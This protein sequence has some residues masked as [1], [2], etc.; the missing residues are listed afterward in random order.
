LDELL[1]DAVALRMRS[2][3]PIGAFLSGGIDSSTVVAMMQAESS[4]NV[5]TY[6]IGFT[7]P[8][9]D[10]A[11]WARAVARRL[12]TD[13]TELYVTG[14]EALGVIP[15]LPAVYDEPFAD[16]SQIPTVLLAQLAK[17]DVSV[18]LSGDGGDELF[19]GYPCACVERERTSAAARMVAVHSLAHRRSPA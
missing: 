13:H 9:R 17:R 16:P 15:T 5:R 14:E 8:E 4:T 1:H 7:D 18:A 12:G 10:E 6:T 11:D 3:V 19:G 2:D